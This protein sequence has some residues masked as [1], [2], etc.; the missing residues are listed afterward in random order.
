MKKAE[1]KATG[2]V[3][4][5]PY[6][7]P[8]EKVE[9]A[10]IESALDVAINTYK[11]A[12]LEYA[13]FTDMQGAMNKKDAEWVNKINALHREINKTEGAYKRSSKRETLEKLYNRLVYLREEMESTIEKKRWLDRCSYRFNEA[14]TD[15]YNAK[16]KAQAEVTKAASEAGYKFIVKI[17]TTAGEIKKYV[18][19]ATRA[20]GMVY[21]YAEVLL[22][23]DVWTVDGICSPVFG[24]KIDGAT[25]SKLENFIDKYEEKYIDAEFSETT[26]AKG[27][28]TISNDEEGFKT[29]MIRSIHNFT[30][31]KYTESIDELKNFVAKAS[32][33]L[34]TKALA[35]LQ[36]WINIART[37]GV[38]IEDYAEDTKATEETIEN[39][40]SAM[41]GQPEKTSYQDLRTKIQVSYRT[42]K[43]G[44][45]SKI[46]AMYRINLRTR[47][48]EFIKVDQ[49]TAKRMLEENGW[50]VKDFVK[51]DKADKKAG[52]KIKAYNDATS[53]R[54]TA[55]LAMVTPAK[56]ERAAEIYGLTV[57]EI[58]A[59]LAK[60]A[61][62]KAQAKA[63][64]ADIATAPAV[65]VEEYAVTPE[66]F[67]VAVQA[68]IDN[69]DSVPT[70]TPETLARPNRQYF[71]Y[72]FRALHFL[73][74][75][76]SDII[77][78]EK[79]LKYSQGRINGL[80]KRFAQG[81]IDE[82]NYALD[83]IKYQR[84]VEKDIDDI[85]FFEKEIVNHL[86]DAVAELPELE[87]FV[88]HYEPND[89]GDYCNML[90]AAKFVISYAQNV[91]AEVDAADI[92][93]APAVEVEVEVEELN[94]QA[95]TEMYNSPTANDIAKA[96]LIMKMCAKRGGFFILQIAQFAIRDLRKPLETQTAEISEK[97]ILPAKQEP[98]EPAKVDSA[99]GNL[100]TA[101]EYFDAND[102][103]SWKFGAVPRIQR[104]T[105]DN[106]LK[107]ESFGEF[108]INHKKWITEYKQERADLAAGRITKKE[109]KYEDVPDFCNGEIFKPD[110]FLKEDYDAL[111]ESVAKLT[112]NIAELEKAIAVLK[113]S[114][115]AEYNKRAE[116]M[117]DCLNKARDILATYKA[118][119]KGDD[120]QTTATVSTCKDA[121][122]TATVSTC[123]DAQTTATVSTCKDAQKY[124]ETPAVEE[125]GYNKFDSSKA[126][127]LE[128][129][130]E[131][132]EDKFKAA[133]TAR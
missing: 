8:A 130:S 85:A 37:E 77:K 67:E 5:N 89:S 106:I 118:I 74:T 44:R 54:N 42:G 117:I 3:R 111:Y 68:E 121:Q 125:S 49:A 73:T 56:I 47:H 97:N 4:I 90:D 50:T 58:K 79:S 84:W 64:A 9:I 66:A 53:G 1:V 60:V 93:T 128:W 104:D 40:S 52:A 122:T 112:A 71:V 115:N 12:E 35:E 105:Q 124:L 30:L 14:R 101:E 16:R 38:E 123:K 119:L 11:A 65:E 127:L 27:E 15:A 18:R 83:M 78:T 55:G 109:L 26:T 41:F 62:E 98:I 6:I 7:A 17:K 13:K 57:E 82:E 133:I 39:D 25:Q 29:I 113:N 81:K 86:P 120:A 100:Q 33:E 126:D 114:D 103:S 131:V 108:Y 69:A 75:D 80:K 10:G 34:R 107:V 32:G 102:I 36:E 43:N 22:S 92:A 46:W 24:Y 129:I 61:T 70:F 19:T 94:L 28:V 51:A 110:E 96:V 87:K 91:A 88:K 45:E 2:E 116:V 59:I 21:Q 48:E 99:K 95:A 63:T 20:A 72:G 23:W 76:V 132:A 31:G